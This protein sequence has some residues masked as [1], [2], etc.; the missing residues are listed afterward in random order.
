[1]YTRFASHGCNFSLGPRFAIALPASS[2]AAFWEA[3][4]RFFFFCGAA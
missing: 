3:V 4:R 2:A 1:M